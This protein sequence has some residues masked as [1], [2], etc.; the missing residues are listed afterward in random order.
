MDKNGSIMKFAMTYVLYHIVFYYSSHLTSL[1]S[2]RCHDNGELLR[3]F[4]SDIDN[5]RSLPLH[6][7]STLSMAMLLVREIRLTFNSKYNPTMSF[8][9]RLP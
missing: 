7:L 9:I 6:A 1:I 2:W 8:V 5:E 3:L 4:R